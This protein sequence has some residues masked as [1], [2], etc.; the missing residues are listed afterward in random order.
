MCSVSSG[1]LTAFPIMLLCDVT[2]VHGQ[3]RAGLSGTFWSVFETLSCLWTSL[4][5]VIGRRKLIFRAA[6]AV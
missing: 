1:G 4:I 5:W 3:S 6:T 2:M